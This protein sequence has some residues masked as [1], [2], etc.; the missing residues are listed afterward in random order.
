M[1]P[2]KQVIGHSLVEL[3][4]ELSQK[5]PQFQLIQNEA[6]RLDVL[7]SDQIPQRTSRRT[8]FQVFTAE[9]LGDALEM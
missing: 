5:E 2:E 9:D 4:A 3:V 8:P 6:R 7:Y 1:P